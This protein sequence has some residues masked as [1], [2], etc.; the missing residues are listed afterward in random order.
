MPDQTLYE[1]GFPRPD[2]AEHAPQAIVAAIIAEAEQLLERQL[3]PAQ[4]ER[5]LANLQAYRETGVRNAV[6]YTGEQ[7]LVAFAVGTHLDYLGELLGC[8][9]LGES[10]A[11]CTLRF[12]LSQVPHYSVIIPQ[13]T[14]AARGTGAGQIHWNTTQSAV[15]RGTVDASGPANLDTDGLPYVDVP[16]IASTNGLIGNGFE[17]GEINRLVT[18]PHPYHLRVENL[19]MTQQGAAV[20]SD[21]RFRRRIMLAPEGFAGGSVGGYQYRVLSVSSAI[22]DVAG[23]PE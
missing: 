22:T 2:F 15:I 12:T 20:E 16:A 7:N 23:C 3:Y 11:T 1:R 17:P 6:Q 14:T 8:Y 13:G 10:P 9:R 21:D 4:V 18:D 19:T 5:L